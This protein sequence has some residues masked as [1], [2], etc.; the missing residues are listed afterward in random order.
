MCV[1]VCGN[2]RSCS[3]SDNA[4]V[5]KW[6]KRG[7]RWPRRGWRAQRTAA[8]MSSSTSSLSSSLSL[9]AVPSPLLR[10][11]IK[12]KCCQ[13]SFAFPNSTC[14]ELLLLP[15]SARYTVLYDFSSSCK[16]SSLTFAADLP[17]HV[18]VTLPPNNRARSLTM[19][20]F[21]KPE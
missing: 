21:I 16:T 10:S 17:L 5:C 2:K 1:I 18:T 15:L 6:M 9:F 19:R 11:F 7:R 14:K 20:R 3:F 12:L 4:Q 8:N 13:S